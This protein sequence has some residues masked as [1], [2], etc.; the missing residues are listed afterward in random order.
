M[1]WFHTE[2]WVFGHGNLFWTISFVVV[3]VFMDCLTVWRKYFPWQ[4]QQQLSEPGGVLI[5]ANQILTDPFLLFSFAMDT[6][7]LT[8]SQL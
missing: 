8:S 2:Q 7:D 1:A 4:Y 5:G 6:I 3:D